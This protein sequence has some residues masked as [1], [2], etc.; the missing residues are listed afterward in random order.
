MKKI[1]SILKL[2]SILIMI[3]HFG[4]STKKT[5]IIDYDVL[6]SWNI[7]TGGVGFD[8]LVSEHASKDEVLKL[9][10]E[11]RNE[12]LSK[13]KVIIFIFDS[14]EAWLNRDNDNY[15]EDEYFRH[16]L[17]R[18]L[19]NQQTGFDEIKWVAKGRDH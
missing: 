14:R 1:Y 18:V 2:F 5:N 3:V 7:P 6:R 4:C 8:I 15:P 19:V 12:N 16:F 17:V 13:G 10:S 9:A 11:L